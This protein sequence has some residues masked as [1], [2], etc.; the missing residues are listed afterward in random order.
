MDS[1]KNNNQYLEQYKDLLDLILIYYFKYSFFIDEENDKN[2]L[3]KTIYNIKNDVKFDNI[4]DLKEKIIMDYKNILVVEK[5][6]HVDNAFVPMLFLFDIFNFSLFER[7]CFLLGYIY[8]YDEKYKLIFSVLNNTQCMYGVSVEVAFNIFNSLG[9]QSVKLCSCFNDLNSS[10]LGFNHSLNKNKPLPIK[11]IIISN[12]LQAFVCGLGY[13]DNDL[14]EFITVY[15]SFEDFNTSSYILLYDLDVYI[16]N[17]N[18]MPK[19]KL[20]VIAIKGAKGCGKKTQARLFAKKFLKPIIIVDFKVF[21]DK[22]SDELREILSKITLKAYIY[23]GVLCFENFSENSNVDIQFILLYLYKFFSFIIILTDDKNLNLNNVNTNKILFNSFVVP[24]LDEKQR[25]DFWNIFIKN[26]EINKNDLEKIARGFVL[27][28]GEI[29]GIIEK[30]YMVKTD[31]Y[32]GNLNKLKN[33]CVETSKY[34]FGDIAFRVKQSFSWDDI[35]LEE[36]CKCKLLNM[37]N[38][39]KYKYKVYNN[40]GFKNKFPYGSGISAL[41]YG[42]PG[43]GKTMAAQIMARQIGCELYKIDLS[44]VV[45]KYVGE[46]EKSLKKIFDNALKTNVILF[47]DE[48]DAIFSKRTNVYNANDKYANIETAYLLQKIEEYEGV[49]ILATNFLSGFDD[50]FKRRIK[51][52]VNFTMPNINNRHILWK[53]SFPKEV[54]VSQ[55]VDFLR[56]AEKYELTGS[57]I[58][59]ISISAAFYAASA[60]DDVISIEHIK[61][62]LKDEFEKNGKVFLKSDMD[63]Y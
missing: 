59:A 56:L 20:N 55:S 24:D 40:W 49:T 60:N 57:D 46:T 37:V 28:V 18:S 31:N 25:A 44:Q 62:A 34:N 50:A 30:Y 10:I 63:M 14:E 6:I 19:S 12:A 43:T 35:I 23:Q 33:L 13:T 61:M 21:I 26:D 5:N 29:K 16:K 8:V 36:D 42:P 9:I 51:F 52:I 38:R 22:T 58:K 17:I 27:T 39:V 3:K 15:S 47:F 4:N 11:T 32:I 1:I 2:L 7:F 48:A 45:D 53:K 54:K 41:F